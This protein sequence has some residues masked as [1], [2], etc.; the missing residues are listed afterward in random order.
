M[1]VL[2]RHL[3]IGF[4]VL[5]V[6]A[7]QA[8]KKNR[9]Q[10]GR[11]YKAGESLYAP[12]FGF[13]GKV[14]EGWEGTLP[15]ESEVFLLTTTTATY[16]EIFVFG[17]DGGTLDGMKAAWAKGF[18]LTESIKLKGVQPT[19]QGDMLVSEVTAAGEYINRGFKG[20]AAA[21]CNVAGPCITTLM[22]APPQYYES[23]KNTVVEFMKG[24]S[25]SNPSTA[26]PYAEFDWKEFLSGKVL[27]AYQ[28]MQGGSKES[29]IHL[30]ADGT[31]Y[32]DI[33]KKGV[34]KDQNPAYRG[35]STG[36]WTVGPNGEST[37]IQFTFDAKEKL[38]PLE[39]PLMIKD[40]QVYSRSERYFAGQ[41]DRCK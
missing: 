30:C 24:S 37:T 8:Q 9:I 4:L 39:A 41:S 38:V 28:S 7:A 32:A 36:K 6:V 12:R 26:S 33:K 5:T 10:P 18:D 21:R 17:R 15:R 13:M 11:M 1:K 40:E 34:F 20:F 25:F 29:M 22:V 31:F 14:P 27:M 3:V 35:T 23:V 16:G 2:T 19:V